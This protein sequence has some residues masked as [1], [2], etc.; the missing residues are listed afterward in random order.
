VLALAVGLGL[1]RFL[2][3]APP[4]STPAVGTVTLA[5]Q[6]AI[7]EE[8]VAARPDDLV[9]LQGLA[10]AYLRR[11]SET[12][13]ASFLELT[14]TML[15]RASAL[16]PGTS[17]IGEAL[18]AL[19]RHEFSAAADLAGRAR[20]RDPYDAAAL[21]ILVDASVELGRYEEAGT[22]LQRLLDLRPALPALTRTAYLREL[23]GDLA[24]AEEAMVQALTAGAG[25]SFDLAVTNAL[26]GDLHLKQGELVGAR[27]RYEEALRL[28]PGL[29]A[30]SKGL[31]MVAIAAG[32]EA[33]AV[34]LLEAV[35]DRYPEPGALVLLGESLLVRGEAAGASVQF[36]TMRA[37][38]R[39]QEAS[40]VVLDL[41]MARFEADHGDPERALALARAAYRERPTVFA[42][43]VLG[44]ALFKAGRPEEAL[45]YVEESLR[46]GTPDA[47]VHLHAAA[48]LEALGDPS[49][50]EAEREAAAGLDPWFTALHPEL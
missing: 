17:L 3:P 45:R 13:D 4:T 49:R 2:F 47:A 43:E 6:V 36:D 31:A 22:H 11:A 18:L 29:V 15:A 23:G 20:A 48:V 37:I 34:D 8:R 32:E 7:L 33:A 38:A 19:A 9:A 42:A 50:A 12:G 5:Q 28:S 27:T 40:G 16:A 24:G 30:A 21:A 46:L 44:W 26:M 14:E 39:L 41:E 10:V 25:S 1:G 35:V